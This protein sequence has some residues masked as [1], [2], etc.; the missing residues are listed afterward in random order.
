M[1]HLTRTDSKGQ[2]R[3]TDPDQ[4]LD[5][6]KRFRRDRADCVV[7]RAAFLA[8]AER[9]L[10]E[11]YFRDGRTIKILAE[12]SN[13][14]PRVLSRRLRRLTERL[15]SDRFSFVLRNFESWSPSRRRVATAMV[16]QGLSMRAASMHLRM[17]LYSV[18]RHADAIN[19]LYDSDQRAAPARPPARRTA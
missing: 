2:W 16:M 13:T 14:D 6:R 1:Q 7:A 9:L 11:S 8:P 4:A 15:L 17:S 10:V 18:R 5:L 12:A 19:A 3:H